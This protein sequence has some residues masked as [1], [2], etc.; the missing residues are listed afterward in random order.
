MDL[1]KEAKGI[2]YVVSECVWRAS[3]LCQKS[4]RQVARHYKNSKSI[5]REQGHFAS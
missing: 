3:V 4:A 1:F 2:K 5:L